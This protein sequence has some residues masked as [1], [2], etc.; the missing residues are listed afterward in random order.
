MMKIHNNQ[1]IAESG[2]FKHPAVSAF[3]FDS[4]YLHLE[5]E[6]AQNNIHRVNNGHRDLVMYHYNDVAL[7]KK[8]IR[9]ECHSV[10]YLARGIILDVSKKNVVALP[11]P[12]FWNYGEFGFFD[13]PETEYQ[14]F[15]KIDGSLGIIYYHNNQWNV[16]TKGS[17][18]SKQGL[19]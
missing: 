15:D 7:Q 1:W 8:P 18:T 17:F 3:D 13:Y 10:T 19:S 12:K 9:W 14:I 2:S 11:F 6:V 4:L 16:T 5:N